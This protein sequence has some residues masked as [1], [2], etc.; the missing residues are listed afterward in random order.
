[1]SVSSIRS[2][3]VAGPS[4]QSEEG[5]DG[6][7]WWLSEAGSPPESDF[8]LK[9]GMERVTLYSWRTWSS[10][11][12]HPSIP[13]S[14][15]R[16]SFGFDSVFTEKQ[17]RQFPWHREAE[18]DSE[19]ELLSLHVPVKSEGGV[20]PTLFSWGC[21]EP[22]LSLDLDIFLHHLLAAFLSA[23]PRLSHYYN[24]KL[25]NTVSGVLSK[26]CFLTL[27]LQYFVLEI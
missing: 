25:R 6:P 11:L 17:G 20:W 27:L 23:V 18:A 5:T 12:W 15:W 2:R 7:G 14:D 24:Q 1:M 22:C 3:G 4:S 26:S 10:S 16:R 8:V 9:G 21:E 19:I 13:R